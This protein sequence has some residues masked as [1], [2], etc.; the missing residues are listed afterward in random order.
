MFII[1]AVV[2]MNYQGETWHAKSGG[3]PKLRGGIHASY[4][5]H[6]VALDAS[7]LTRKL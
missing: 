3:N 4:W 6:M 2:H 7:H 1:P 5:N